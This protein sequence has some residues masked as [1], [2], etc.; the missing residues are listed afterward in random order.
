MTMLLE[1]LER[2]RAL[3]LF[4][5]SHLNRPPRRCY[6]HSF[7]FLFF[8]THYLCIVVCG[9]AKNKKKK[10]TEMFDTIQHNHGDKVKVF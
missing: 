8:F 5:S 2:H 1:F 7:F 10:E 9:V 3:H 4:R 6:H